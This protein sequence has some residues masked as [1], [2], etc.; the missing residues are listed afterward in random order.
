MLENL[1]DVILFASLAH[2]DQLMMDPDFQRQVGEEACHGV[3]DYLKVSYKTAPAL[4]Y[5]IL[6]R[7]SKGDKVKYLQYK[8]LSKLYN[9]GE[10]DGSFGPK[11]DNAVRRFQKDNGLVVDGIVGKNT[12]NKL[13]VIG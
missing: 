1:E 11:V 6:K 12:W 7:G 8:L 5:P 3:C 10:I 9:P 4:T 2:K 13:K